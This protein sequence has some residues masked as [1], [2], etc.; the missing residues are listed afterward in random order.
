VGGAAP[1]GAE[2]SV[3]AARHPAAN[4]TR[5]R[6]NRCRTL[7]RI[8]KNRPVGVG[9][10]LHPEVPVATGTLQNASTVPPLELSVVSPPH[11][12]LWRSVS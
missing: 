8:A 9:R 1:A 12:P 3:D 6:G 11:P 10:Y 7:L 2:T 5:E 4:T